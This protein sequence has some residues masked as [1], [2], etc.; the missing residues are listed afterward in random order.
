MEV[1]QTYKAYLA[2]KQANFGSSGVGMSARQVGGCTT[3]MESFTLS[4]VADILKK[5]RADMKLQEKKFKKG[6][7]S[8]AS[9]KGDDNYS[10]VIKVVLASF[11]VPAADDCRSGALNRPCSACVRVCMCAWMC[12]GQ[13][14]PHVR[15]VMA[16]HHRVRWC[17]APDRSS[18]LR[19]SPLFS[20]LQLQTCRIRTRPM[21]G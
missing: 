7:D 2:E 9:G 18:S 12:V 11:P 16:L 14:G 15:P 4:T 3:D 6:D 20:P 19:F 1:K 21:L 17:R 5:A 13:D 8:S 10:A